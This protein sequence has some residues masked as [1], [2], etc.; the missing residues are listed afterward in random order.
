MPPIDQISSFIS[1]GVA[2]TSGG[3]HAT[4][5][6]NCRSCRVFSSLIFAFTP[7]V[8]PYAAG[9]APRMRG[10]RR[11]FLITDA[12]SGRPG[13]TSPLGSG[14]AVDAAALNLAATASSLVKTTPKLVEAIFCRVC[15]HLQ[16]VDIL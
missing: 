2:R 8:R 10:R 9:Q 3:E 5:L 15:M 16:I 1:I 11:R 12:P 7:P 6:L 4:Q 14:K 13:P